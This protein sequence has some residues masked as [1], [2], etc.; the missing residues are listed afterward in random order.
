M[1]GSKRILIMSLMVMLTASISIADDWPNWRGSNYDAIS[2]ETNWNAA[3]LD[4]PV[5][6]WKAEIGTGFSTICVANGKAYTSGNINNDT[7]VIYCFD[8]ITGNEQWTYKYP[9]PLTPNNYEGGVNTTPTVHDGKVY[10]LSKTG[11]VFCL[12]ATTGKEVWK[13]KLSAG[14]PRWGFAGSPVIVD[15][16][17]IYNV[18]ASGTALKKA[19]GSPAWKS[20]DEKAGY[21]SAVPFARNGTK[22]LAMFCQKSLKIVA[23]E[24]GNVVM[25]HEW[26][27][28]WD[29][30]A[31]D[32]IISGDEIFITSGYGHGG[33][34][35]KITDD[36]LKEV[37]M[38]KNM[39][40][41]MSGP[42]LIDG[43]LYGID[44]KQLACVEWK[45]GKQM[46]AEKETKEGSLCAAGDKLI[47]IGEKGK[48]YIAAASPEGFKV[49]SSAQVLTNRCWTMPVLANGY[50]YVRNTVKNE[51]DQLVCL[52]VRNKKDDKVLTLAVLPTDKVEWPQWKGPHRDNLSTETGLLKQWPEKGPSLLWSV[53]GLGKGFSTVSI[54]DG[55]IYT[56]GML[57]KEGYLFCFDLNGKPLWKQSYGGEWERSFQGARCTPTVD[58]GCVYVVSSVGKVGCFKA[59]TG[60]KIWMVDPIEAFDGKYANWGEAQSPLVID[61]KVI[62]IVGGDKVMVVALDQTTGKVLWTTSGN[63]DPSV[64]CSPTSFTWGGK[65]LVAGMTRLNIFCLDAEDG[66]LLWTY[67]VANYCTGKIHNAHPNTPYFKDGRLFFT[68]GYDMGA[69]QLKLSPDGS[70]VEQAWTNVEMDSHHGSFVVLDGHIYA[71][72]WQSNRK[73][74]WIC[75]DW[76][77]GKT[78]YEETWHNKGSIACADGMLYCYEEGDGN[79]GLVKAD[80]KGFEVVSSFQVTQGEGEHWAHPVICGKRLYIRHGD[81]LMAYDIDG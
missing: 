24:T 6:A 58:N 81:V 32:P 4:N 51:M 40:S 61:G 15:D 34:L 79:V 80:P 5:I 52:D 13:R 19:D 37:W 18:G 56:T 64:Y 69:V 55:K 38:N 45:T 63:G 27:T 77:T 31:A 59:E 8:A 7:D 47:V 71:P 25:S 21:A 36:G 3:A 43:Y 26:E 14:K 60:E 50:I 23:T 11:K 74:N 57:D 29:V 67:P 42:V 2:K 68:S 44:D 62:Y 20:E 78:L 75:A 48:L 22:Y 53:E 41:R 30:N 46:W 35:L 65:T 10:T 73:G 16:L 72:N 49:L 54:A 76:E 39:R 66:S 9:E 33:S 1:D 28:S 70:A 12:D 17:V